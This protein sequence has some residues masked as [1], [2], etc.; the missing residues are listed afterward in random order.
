MDPSSYRR[1]VAQNIG[2]IG[3]GVGQQDENDQFSIGF[4][5]QDF[6]ACEG[7]S[8]ECPKC[9]RLNVIRNAATKK[10]NLNYF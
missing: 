7:I 10:V 6:S 5:Q 3:F 1:K 2:N 8:Y 9:Q 4:N